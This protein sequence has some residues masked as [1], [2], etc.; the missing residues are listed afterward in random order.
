MLKFLIIVVLVSY[1]LFKVIQFLFKV[2]IIGAGG[3]EAYR[4]QQGYQQQQ[5]STRQKRGDISIDYVPKDGKKNSSSNYDG[6]EYVDYEEV[7]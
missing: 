4:R 3:Q 6:G 5:N 2:L 7:K 1:L